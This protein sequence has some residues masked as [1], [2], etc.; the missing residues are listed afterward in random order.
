[1]CVCVGLHIL[2]NNNVLLYSLLVRSDPVLPSSQLVDSS[3][4]LSVTMPVT[5]LLVT[6]PCNDLLDLQLQSLV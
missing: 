5:Q 4:T 1:M 6:V 3:L 2:Y